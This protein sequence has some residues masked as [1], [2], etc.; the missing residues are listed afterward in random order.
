MNGF[1]SNIKTIHL[2]LT[3]AVLSGCGMAGLP[4]TG[5]VTDAETGE[6]IEGA[7]V[8][9]KWTGNTGVVGSRSVC[10]HVET[11][12]SNKEGKFR[13]PGWFG[14]GKIYVM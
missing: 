10:Y 5:Q 1:L 11:A 3:L 6:P 7:I 14:G 9:A 2:I 13:I 8:V 12:I 4:F